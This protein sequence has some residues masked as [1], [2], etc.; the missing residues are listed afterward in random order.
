VKYDVI[1]IGA[2][3]GGL[4]AA[5]K[6]SSKLKVAIFETGK[7]I[8]KRVCP[9]N[10]QE[11]HCYKC[12]PCNI[13]SGV[14]GAG[15]LSDGK[16]NYISP[17]YLSSYSVGGEFNFLD[18][19]YLGE[20]MNEVDK[21]FLENGAA[22]KSYGEDKEKIEQLLKRA[23]KVGIEFVPL[24]QRHLGSDELPKIVKNL[25]NYLKQ[26]GVEIFTEETVLDINPK[27]RQIRTKRG[28]TYQY[29]FL[30]IAVGREGANFLEKWVKEYDFALNN[31]EKAIDVG[32]RIEVPASIMDE[33][34]SIVYDPKLRII[35]KKHDDY[36]RT[37]CTCPGGWVIRENYDDFCLVNGHSKAKEKTNNT[38]FALIGHY[39]FTEP[40]K[41]PNEWGRD[42]ARLTTKLGGG[43]VILQ[44]LKDL[45]FGR[46]SNLSRI[47][48]NKLVQP[49]LKTAMPGDISLAY[50]WR[51]IEDILD[52]LDQLDKF[53]PGVAEDSTLIYAPEIK[54]YSLK[55]KVDQRM[56]TNISYVYTIGDGA[57]ISRGIVGA[58]VTGLIAGEDIN[59]ASKI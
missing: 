59:K 22:N 19:N 37:F 35:T 28:K 44:R 52:A 4:F 9:S 51:V 38:N 53:L 6:L 7:D 56:R 41:Y 47:E 58:A 5:H 18:K 54:F 30:I 39:R 24:K 13:T 49:T 1:I 23:N 12:S 34:T 21:I 45:R 26:K 17:E 33:I 29:D 55:L 8:E 14:G 15:G 10:S 16:L 32:V 11:S 42:L 25:E 50:P 57:G 36:L 31:N 43:N 48:N 27:K 2:G 20:K 3:P 46:R 40:F